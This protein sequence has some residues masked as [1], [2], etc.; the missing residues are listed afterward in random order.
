MDG[1]RTRPTLNAPIKTI[2]V[3]IV[4]GQADD[5]GFVGGTAVTDVLNAC[6]RV[7]RVSAPRN[8]NMVFA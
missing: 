1:D 8:T 3:T 7:N 6:T 5:V 4:S 2:K